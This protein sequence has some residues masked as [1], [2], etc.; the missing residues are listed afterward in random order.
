[1]GE[2]SEY[3]EDFPEEDPGNYDER[4]RFVPDR[5]QRD[6]FQQQRRFSEIPRHQP[7]V[8]RVKTGV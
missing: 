6:E 5:R 2:W 3:F 4:G 8:P 1:M 7:P